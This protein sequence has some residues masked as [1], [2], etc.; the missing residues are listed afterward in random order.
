MP[1]SLP[2]ILGRAVPTMVVLSAA[3]DIP[4]INATITMIFA[5]LVIPTFLLCQNV[6]S[7]T[8]MRHSYS[9]RLWCED[10]LLGRGESLSC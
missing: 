9:H 6:C 5:R 3:R 1:P 2:A 8:A 7:A 10:K 4:S